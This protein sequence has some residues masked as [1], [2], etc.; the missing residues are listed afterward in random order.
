MKNLLSIGLFFLLLATVSNVQSE[1][2]KIVKPENTNK[3]FR[4]TFTD[5]ADLA[6][7]RSALEAVES[8]EI[9]EYCEAQKAFLCK[10]NAT[11]Y[12]S[13]TILFNAVA[14][15]ASGLPKFFITLL[16]EQDVQNS[17]K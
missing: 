10:A 12:P 14:H 15:Q 6:L 8:L 4:I 3:A 7:T 5:V 17:C 9:I 13:H 1:N 16:T 11:L 2:N